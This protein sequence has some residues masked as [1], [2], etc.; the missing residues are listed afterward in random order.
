ME[1]K[2]NKFSRLK[3]LSKILDKCI[4]K[5]REHKCDKCFYEKD[6]ALVL[7]CRRTVEDLLKEI[8]KL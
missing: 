5:N 1:E 8:D 3:E 4:E 7:V 2:E 6:G